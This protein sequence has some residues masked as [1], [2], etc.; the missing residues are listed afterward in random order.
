MSATVD[1]LKAHE[2]THEYLIAIDSDGCAFDTME[3][4]QKECFVPN[5]VKFWGLQAISKYARAASEFV[6][7]Y[8][9]W[10]GLNRFPALLK[11]FDLLD[12]W[13]KV[14]ARGFTSPEAPHL[15]EWVKTETKLGNAA[16]A[17]YCAA[18]DHEDMHR[19]LA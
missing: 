3:I 15:R 9:R 12:D 19:T 13:D 17:A 11:V 5:H 18:H 4:K 14:Q 6:N 7:L 16:L 2:A 8:S 10:R 1:S